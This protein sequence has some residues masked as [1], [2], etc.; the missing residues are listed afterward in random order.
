MDYIQDHKTRLQ[1]RMPSRLRGRIILSLLKAIGD[2]VQLLEDETFDHYLSE[3]INLAGGVM[4]DRWGLIVGEARYGLDDSDYRRILEA[5]L[6]A[7]KA[8]GRREVIVRVVGLLFEEEKITY[9]NYHTHFRV[10]VDL[11]LVPSPAYERRVLRLVTFMAVVG[12]SGTIAVGPPGMFRL[13]SSA[14]FGSPLGRVL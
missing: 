10:N 7:L 1:D 8:A 11:G 5:R 12:I 6:L 4:L 2:E 3:N 9:S 13:S 14:G